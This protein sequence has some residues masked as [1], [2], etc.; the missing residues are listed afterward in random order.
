MRR[1][2][3]NKSGKADPNN[4]EFEKLKVMLNVLQSELMQV[5]ATH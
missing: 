3:R 5:K 2:C 1:L 4:L